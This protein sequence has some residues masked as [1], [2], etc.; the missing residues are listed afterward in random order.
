MRAIGNLI[1]ISNFHGAKV[2]FDPSIASSLSQFQYSK[3]FVSYCTRSGLVVEQNLE[4]V[5]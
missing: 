1:D 4:F 3:C 2:L 5:E